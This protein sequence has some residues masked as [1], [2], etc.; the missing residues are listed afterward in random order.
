MTGPSFYKKNFYLAAVSQRLRNTALNG[1]IVWG[2]IG[3][4]KLSTLSPPHRRQ[5]SDVTR[6]AKYLL[7]LTFVCRYCS[8]WCRFIRFWVCVSVAEGIA[9]RAVDRLWSRL[10]RVIITGCH[11]HNLKCRL[12]FFPFRTGYYQDFLFLLLSVCCTPLHYSA[13]YFIPFHLKKPPLP[14]LPHPSAT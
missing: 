4:F 10:S 1:C 7:R 5:L 9:V 14:P 3:G 12:F 11:P 8:T 13:V 2:R 6:Q